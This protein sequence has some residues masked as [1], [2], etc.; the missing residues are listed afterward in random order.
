[1]AQPRTQQDTP[2]VQVDPLLIQLADSVSAATTLEE[3]VRPLLEMLE[4]VTGLESTYLTTIDLQEGFQ[5]I[6]FA[7]NSD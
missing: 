6:L 5:H 2:L 1:M 4:E 7:R 3:L